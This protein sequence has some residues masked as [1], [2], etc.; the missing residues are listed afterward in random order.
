MS[1]II[2]IDLDCIENDGTNLYAATLGT[3]IHLFELRPDTNAHRDG[4]YLTT[5]DDSSTVYLTTTEVDGEVTILNAETMATYDTIPADD[6]N[7]NFIPVT[8]LHDLGLR[9]LELIN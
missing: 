4:D 3:G 1:E 2:N 7:G 6:L 8:V 5:E 9:S